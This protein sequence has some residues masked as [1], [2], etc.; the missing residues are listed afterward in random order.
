V[1]AVP[2]IA[3]LTT[4]LMR[5]AKRLDDI[6]DLTALTAVGMAVSELGVTISARILAVAAHPNGKA[7]PENGAGEPDVSLTIEQA[8]TRLHRSTK[9]IYRHRASLPFIRKIG[10][11]SYIASQRALEHWLAQRR[12]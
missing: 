4:E 12:V 1:A 6:N 11:R 3:A 2:D 9:W 5:A 8:A 10:P 7:V